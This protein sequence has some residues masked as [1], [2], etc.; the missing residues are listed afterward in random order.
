M[1]PTTSAMS[2][3]TSGGS[4]ASSMVDRSA[5]ARRLL[6]EGDV[7]AD[8]VSGAALVLTPCLPRWAGP[9]RQHRS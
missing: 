6:G 4:S 1:S 9:R 3:A 8:G 2:S 5:V 7:A